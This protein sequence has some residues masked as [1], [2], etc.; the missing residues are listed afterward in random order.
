MGI[1]AH[2]AKLSERSKQKRTAESER[3]QLQQKLSALKRD[4]QK[5]ESARDRAADELAKSAQAISEANRAL[6]DLA[7]EQ[8]Q[9]QAR[10]EQLSE[11]QTKLNAMVATRQKQL[12]ELLRD[13][14]M[15]GGEDR[16]KLLLSGD[17]PNRISREL[18][19]LSYV[20]KAQAALIESLRAD[21]KKI[22]SNKIETQAAKGELDEIAEETRAQK[23]ALEKEK[24]KHAALLAQISGK[25]AAQRKEAGN[26]QRD[27]QRLGSLVNKLSQLIEQQQKEEAA[28]LR[29][30]Q[31][32]AQQRKA[33]QT[34][35]AS[36]QPSKSNPDAID[37]DVPPQKSYGRNELTPEPSVQAAVNSPPFS[38][39]RGQLR[40]PIRGELAAKFGTRRDDGP[41]WKG[42]FI[43]APEG[44]EVKAVA[45]GRVVFADWLRGFGN[46][47]ILDHSNQYLTIYGYNQAVLKHA[48]DNVKAGDV[49]ASAGNSGGHAQSG[50]YFEMR[51]QGRAFDPLEW[52]V[53]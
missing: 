29:R 11:Q 26:I 9:T 20:S 47:I 53:R 12:A 22:E 5:T 34:K 40:L 50:L 32:R 6:H 51:Y 52:V 17:N 4:I 18:M 37:D 1:S 35:Q 39:L 25:L 14:Y 45:A 38:S 8:R 41:V 19:Y 7:E 33:R 42:L 16:V 36:K 31:A 28:A 43:R 44:T 46:L 49:I 27:E 2:A 48:G 24:T 21:L 15:S 3:A 23:D 13:Q 10:I 30:K